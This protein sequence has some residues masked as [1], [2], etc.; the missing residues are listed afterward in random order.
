MID[1][2]ES[3]LKRFSEDG[4]SIE[5]IRDQLE[6]FETGISFVH[7][8][9]A[10]L[11]GDGIVKL[12]DE[13]EQRLI[14]YYDE[15]T[16]ELQIVKFVPSSGAASRMFKMLFH[17]LETYQPEK[18]S[19]G[20][21]LKRTGN[22]ELTFFFEKQTSL[23]FFELV[24][25]RIKG[26]ATSADA[27][28]Y[29]FVKE[30]LLEEGCNYSFYPKAL[31]PFHKYVDYVAT[32]FEEHLKEAAQYASVNG[33]A[34]L[35]FTI[36]KHHGQMFNLEFSRIKSRVSFETKN[37]F[38]VS[39]SYQ[40]PST[41]TIAVTPDNIPYRDSNGELVFRPGGHGSL[42]ENLN[43][44][45]A[46]LIF[47]KNIDN[48]AIPQDAEQV[49]NSKKVLGGL[50]LNLQE[51]AFAYARLL[52]VESLN[53]E[54][55]EEIKSFLETRL[56]VRLSD[57]YYSCSIQQQIEILKDKISR[58][59]RVCGMVKNTGEPGGGPF[60]IRDSQ[61][62]VSLQI[63]ESAQVD[64]KNE[65]QMAIFRNASHFN[66]VDVVCGVRDHENEKYNLLNFVDKKQGFISEKTSE[67]VKI[68]ALELP[69]L[70]N[71]AMAFWNTVFVEVPV[72]T[73]NPVKTVN[74][75][76]KP[77]HQSA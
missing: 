61:G 22:A 2:T 7:L 35:H 29:L 66:P 41:D 48:V 52:D 47:I 64:T 9:R 68:K 37:S 34:H 26:K 65:E 8:E 6:I 39:Y 12:S 56:N 24:N 46:D 32:P 42:I 19:I 20:S 44:Q 31:L 11:V 72:V 5:Q 23:P 13:E 18:E 25:N 36:S 58:P 27:E 74:D 67:G 53:G 38:H 3:E 75:L 14:R 49:M 50:L 4:I 69:G 17:F 59:L 1:F 55:L 45:E 76:L 51:Q 57:K 63:I 16:R 43:E 30:M 15:S 28:A 77:S 54:Q 73:F 62:N 10:A 60:W 21:Y 70:W 40:W 33:E 71:G